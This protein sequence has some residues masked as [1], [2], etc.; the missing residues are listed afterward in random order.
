MAQR[1]G[2]RRKFVEKNQKQIVKKK[3]FWDCPYRQAL[4]DCEW[5]AAAP[6]LKPRRL[7]RA[8]RKVSS[9]DG[10]L[11]SECLETEVE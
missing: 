2:S 4:A 11:K 1:T 7:P 5:R 9:L 3:F 6:G 8:P 10:N